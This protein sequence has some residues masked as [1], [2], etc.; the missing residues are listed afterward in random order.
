MEVR[1]E[2]T[3]GVPPVKGEAKSMLSKGHPQAHR[4]RRL[5]LA[6]ADAMIDRQPLTGA[7]S[8]DVTV[9]APRGHLLPDATNM[10]GGIGDV[11]QARRSGADVEHLGD[12]DRA[13]CYYDDAQIQAIKYRRFEGDEVGCVVIVRPLQ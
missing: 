5:L 11:L 12:L 2:V 9:N 3:G 8:V 7:I 4:V 10:L 13:A 6:A 1:I